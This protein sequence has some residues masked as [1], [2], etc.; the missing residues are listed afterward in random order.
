[1]N[2]RRLAILL[3]LALA[4]IGASIWL[5]A[6]RAPSHD[7]AV[8]EP[9]L[10]GLAAELDQVSG[11]RIVGAGNRTL[12]TL[13]RQNGSWLVREVGY[14][15]DP[16]RVRRLLLAL[17][18]LRVTEEKTRDPAGHALLGVADV[19][20]PEAQGLRLELAG[21]ATPRALLVGRAAGTQGSY[22][23]I[24]D[25]PQALEARPALEVERAPRGWLARTVADVAAA[26]VQS[27]EIVRGDGHG[28]RAAKAQRDAAHY[29]VEGLPRGRE[30][31]HAGAPDA[32]AGALGN[33]EFDDLRRVPPRTAGE[34]PE[35]ATF[36]TFDGLVLD[37]EGRSAGAERW[38]TLTATAD[39]ALAAR[40]A[41]AA[42]GQAPIAG[43]Q[44]PAAGLPPA[45][46]TASGEAQAEAQRITARA[47]GWEYRLAPFRYDALFRS[48]DEL[49]RH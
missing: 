32:T 45:A 5:G 4:V 14:A 35:R 34:H 48:R 8:G 44:A 41:P 47:A 1:M 30:L 46:T 7:T 29:A 17:G 18:D 10:G 12:V 20:D 3:A 23:R 15:A 11:I 31:T 36:R 27:F 42:G 39:P 24:P 19:Q 28:W 2:A 26:R 13:D 43:G 6:R 25:Q 9:V 37:F 22:V 38:I 49:L 40:F 21:P 33:L 16:A